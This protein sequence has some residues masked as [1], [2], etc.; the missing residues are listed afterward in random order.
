[1]SNN[2]Y[3]KQLKKFAL[4]FS[5]IIILTFIVILVNLFANKK[6]TIGLKNILSE[7]LGEEY[8]LKDE[9]KIL[10]T[11]KVGAI[12]FEAKKGSSNLNVI[13]LRVTTLYGPIPCIFIYDTQTKTT[14][15]FDYVN[16]NER[17]KTHLPPTETDKV[18][19]YW[20]NKIPEIITTTKEGK[21]E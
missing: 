11:M 1:M 10:N 15:F 17:I 9:V 3:K 7:N 20:T 16:V 6:N 12:C 21:N 14:T 2:S 5:V 8:I 13:L 19:Q 4:F 18:I